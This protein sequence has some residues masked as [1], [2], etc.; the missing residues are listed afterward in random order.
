MGVQ[1]R[2]WGVIMK[3]KIFQRRAIL[4]G[5][6]AL[7][8]S[9][10]WLQAQCGAAANLLHVRLNLERLSRLHVW[11]DHEVAFR[12]PRPEERL[13]AGPPVQVLHFWADWC[14]PCREE[15]PLVQKLSQ[16][17]TERHRSKARLVCVAEIPSSPDMERFLG[18]QQGRMPQGPYYQDTAELVA[19]ELRPFLPKGSWTL[20]L[21]LTIDHQRVI[22]HVIVGALASHTAELLPI[23]QRL[24]D[25]SGT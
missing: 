1:N 21:T 13:T 22:R 2:L 14:K 6:G 20:P 23:C 10:R 18:A 15:F 17:L 16:V 24:V 25:L 12:P 7:L 8:L 9:P 3:G 11:D 5:L 19:N 4:G